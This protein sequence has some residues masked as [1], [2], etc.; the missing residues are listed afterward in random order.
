MSEEMMFREFYENSVIGSF[1]DFTMHSGCKTF[2]CA[3]L[4]SQIDKWNLEQVR[5]FIDY[6]DNHSGLELCCERRLFVIAPNPKPSNFPY[7]ITHYFEQHGPICELLAMTV[8]EAIIDTLISYPEATH[9]PGK[10][11]HWMN[12]AIFSGSFP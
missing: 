2:H 3:D 9:A 5:A 10:L 11:D 1:D 6:F 7:R 4:S 12:D 8:A